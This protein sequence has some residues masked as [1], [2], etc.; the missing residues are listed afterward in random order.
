MP[1]MPFSPCDTSAVSG[2]PCSDQSVQILE[3]IFG[4]VIRTITQGGDPNTQSMASNVLAT[5][6]STFNTGLLSV[7]GIIVGYVA[8]M[9]VANTANDGEAFGKNWSTWW[10]PARIIYGGGMLL[11]TS[12]GYNIAQIV[13]FTMALWGVGFANSIYNA[14]FTMSVVT[15]DGLVSGVNAPGALF[16]MRDFAKHYLEASYCAH[17]ANAIYNPP[18]GTAV[19]FQ[20]FSD[21]NGVDYT[22][23]SG[24]YSN[25]VTK[26]MDRGTGFTDAGK[27]ACGIVTLSSYTAQPKNAQST[28]WLG[29]GTTTTDVM[30]L[31]LESF[32]QTVQDYKVQAAKDLMKNLDAWVATWPTNVN[33][34]AWANV[35]TNQFN[36]YVTQAEDEVAMHMAQAMQNATGTTDSHLQEYA[37]AMTAGGW[38]TAGG[39]F[40]RV[41]M[42]RGQL[43][44]LM[45]D[46]VGT[47]TPPALSELPSGSWGTFEL[48]NSVTAVTAAI[49]QKADIHATSNGT[50]N[51]WNL[52]LSGALSSSVKDGN[53]AA[54]QTAMNDK[55]G[56]WVNNLMATMVGMVTGANTDGIG[57]GKKTPGCGTA[58]QLGGSLNRMKCVGD[59]LVASSLVLRNLETTVRVGAAGLEFAASA[60]S[61][62]I[63]GTGANLTGMVVAADSLVSNWIAPLIVSMYTKTNNMALLFGVVL[64]SMPYILFMMVVVGWILSVLMTALAVPLWMCLHMTPERTFIGSQRQGYLLLLSLFVRPAL[65]V[66]GLIAAFLVSDP[67]IDY[68]SSSF[69]AMRAAIVSSTG[70]V[71]WIAQFD[72]FYWWFQMYGYLLIPVL[73]MIFGL[74]QALPGHVLKYIG[75]GVDDLGETNAQNKIAGAQNMM[76]AENAQTGW[77]GGMGALKNMGGGPRSPRPPTTPPRLGNDGSQS[78]NG[79]IGGG[80]GGNR[81]HGGNG[82]RGWGSPAIN[83]GPQ[84]VTSSVASGQDGYNPPAQSQTQ[85]GNRRGAVAE[86]VGAA[87]GSA[88]AGRGFKQAIRDGASVKRNGMAATKRAMH[89]ENSGAVAPVGESTEPPLVSTPSVNPVASAPATGSVRSRP[90]PLGGDA[91]GDTT[92]PTTMG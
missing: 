75:G 7:A 58:G 42:L 54:I 63:L 19:D 62:K 66:M 3:H 82:G 46:P 69:F 56:G 28:S 48:V 20:A 5:M 26:I 21:H 8:L 23:T 57:N 77:G 60:G 40:Q 16:G 85:T 11:P 65:A 2:A 72:T 41:G 64:P 53:V 15:P 87:I 92:L 45:S 71:G 91:D 83:A 76:L 25:A 32:H 35:D 1:A 13:V 49:D 31:A 86:G 79:G 88:F 9:G 52:D 38:A 50:S 14:A 70:V 12:S 18:G 89:P 33:D 17:A 73:Y 39:W 81:P 6:F 30:G 34:T 10:T 4:P 51:S 84:G 59:Y 37:K 36:T 55:V 74:P 24:G 78:P 68:I 47:V 29:L 22:T 80:S 90:T 67:I 43:T 61:F 27:G 44:G